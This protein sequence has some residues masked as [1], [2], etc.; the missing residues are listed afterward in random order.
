LMRAP[1]ITS[2]GRSFPVETRW[3]DAPLK[4]DRRRRLEDAA[5]ELVRRALE[6]EPGDALVFLPGAGEI[7]A[8][9]SRL[10]GQ[11]SDGVD[12]LP[13]Y[14]GLPFAKQQQALRPSSPG[15]RKVVLA[16][17]I[18]ETSLTIEGV[19]IV[20]D[21]GRSR[22]ARFDPSSGMSRLVTERASKAAAAQRR[23]RAGRLEDG[24][25]YRL[26]S[27]GEEGALRAFD[28]PEI[29]EA[30]LAPLALELA[31]WGA[32]PSGLPFLD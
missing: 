29:I 20:I 2:E 3:L 16:T 4:L 10:A 22:R 18:A 8:V 30:D 14:G 25:C 24:V 5:A 1:I 31:Q 7:H 32:A 12:I 21:A 23:G 15:R 9:E 28:P 19:R 6:E 17:A 11:V 26:W 13:I 27:K